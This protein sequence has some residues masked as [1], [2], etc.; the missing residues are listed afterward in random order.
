LLARRGV[1][2]RGVSLSRAISTAF[3]MPFSSTAR[4]QS[5]DAAAIA[6]PSVCPTTRSF[7]S[8]HCR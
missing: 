7:I 6:P 1:G 2:G 3:A 8:A 4:L 5:S